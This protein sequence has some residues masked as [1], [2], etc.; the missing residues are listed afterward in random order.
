MANLKVV[1]LGETAVDNGGPRREFFSG[2]VPYYPPS[3]LLLMMLTDNCKVKT[4]DS[5][6]CAAQKPDVKVESELMGVLKPC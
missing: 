6:Q 1:F 5:I 4:L 3:D 2:D